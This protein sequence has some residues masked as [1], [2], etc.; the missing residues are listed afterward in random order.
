M[1]RSS[2]APITTRSGRMKSSTAAPSFRNSGFDTTANGV[3][4]PRARS[5]SLTTAR[6]RSAVPTGTVDLSTMIL[7]S[8]IRRPMFLAAART[9]FMSA[10]PS[11]SG[12][13][14]T[15]MNCRT[16]CATAASWSVVKRS[17]PAATLRAIIAASP[18]SWI[19]TPPASS[20]P[21]FCASTSRQRTSLPTS[22]RQVPVTRPT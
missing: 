20:T 18:G 9:Y 6:T 22:A 1:A 8:V 17:R 21:I 13:V 7:Y 11:S 12:G 15:A 3:S 5:S 19:G 4:T 14:P 10:D 16:P 2:S